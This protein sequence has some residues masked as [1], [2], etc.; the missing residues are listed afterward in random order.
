MLQGISD[1]YILM[2]AVLAA[3]LLTIAFA[4]GA[5][6]YSRLEQEGREKLPGAGQYL[7]AVILVL[8]FLGGSLFFVFLSSSP[9]P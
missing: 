9:T 6:N 1:F 4:W 5:W 3:N 8:A 2:G 7:S